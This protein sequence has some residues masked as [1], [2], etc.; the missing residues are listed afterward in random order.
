MAS[1]LEIMI[2]L[3]YWT[4]PTEY[5]RGDSEHWQS[6]AVQ[7]TLATFVERGLLERL[8][9][10]NQYGGSYE[11]TEALGVWVEALCNI[12]MPVQKWIIPTS[13]VGLTRVAPVVSPQASD[14]GH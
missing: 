2:G 3:H 11:G 14:Q 9:A 10:R 13:V 5:D 7:A 12:P 6:Q 1:P 8:E 4:T